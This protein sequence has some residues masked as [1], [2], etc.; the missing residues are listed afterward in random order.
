ME[1]NSKLI[2]Q[3]SKAAVGYGKEVVL[4]DVSLEVFENDFVYF[5]SVNAI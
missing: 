2:L 3:V 5:L 1:Q 4:R